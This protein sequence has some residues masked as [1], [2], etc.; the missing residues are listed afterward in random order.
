MNDLSLLAPL[1]AAASYGMGTLVISACIY[2]H[3]GSTEKNNDLNNSIS[4]LNVSKINIS[5]IHDSLNTKEMPLLSHLTESN[6]M[7]IIFSDHKYFVIINAQDLI[8]NS[9]CNCY[10]KIPVDDTMNIEVCENIINTIDNC[11]SKDIE[12]FGWNGEFK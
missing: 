5:Y 1:I 7:P 9:I 3:N 12:M 4:M 11:K 2:S 6:L 8:D 10:L